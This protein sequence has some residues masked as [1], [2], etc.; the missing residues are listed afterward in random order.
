MKLPGFTAAD[1]LPAKAPPAVLPAVPP[2]S[3]DGAVVPQ[4][5]YRKGI[6]LC[7]TDPALGVVC[8]VYWN[9]QALPLT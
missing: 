9:V 6:T 7:C 5:C 2:P 4:F 3:P 8:K 1:S